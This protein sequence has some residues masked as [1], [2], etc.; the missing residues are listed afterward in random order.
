MI[1][2]I[3]LAIQASLI[4]MFITFVLLIWLASKA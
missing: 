3:L 1:E 4:G 2:F